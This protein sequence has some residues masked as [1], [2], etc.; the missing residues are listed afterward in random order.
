MRK[1]PIPLSRLIKVPLL[2]VCLAVTLGGGPA[3][4]SWLV[5]PPNIRAKDFSIIKHDGLYHVFYIRHNNQLPNALTVTD[6]GHASSPDLY[7]W[8]H[9]PPILPRPESGWER[10]L[11]RIGAVFGAHRNDKKWT[12]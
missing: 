12:H 2:L 1:G 4:A 7:N 8:T 10:Y 9:L 3:L 6:L 5:P 11:E